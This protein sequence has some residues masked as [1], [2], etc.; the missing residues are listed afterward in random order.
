[1]FVCWKLRYGD[2]IDLTRSMIEDEELVNDGFMERVDRNSMRGGRRK[3]GEMD[4]GDWWVATES[5]VPE[6]AVLVPLIFYTDKTWLS[7][8][9]KHSIQ[10]IAFTLGNFPLKT[11]NK[12]KAK[13][14]VCYVPELSASEVVRRRDLFK[15]CSRRLYHD[16][17][18][19]VLGSVRMAQQNGG[20]FAVWKGRWV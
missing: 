9:G 16:T 15:R 17:W 12:H 18:Y 13:K 3:Y 2:V 4:T 14:I 11:M 5:S 1:M 10:P 8:S 6:D 20:F 19:E 7:R